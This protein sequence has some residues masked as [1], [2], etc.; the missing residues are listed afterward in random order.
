MASDSLRVEPSRE[1]IS[2]AILG[3]LKSWPALP[4]QVFIDVH[5]QGRSVEEVA[6]SRQMSSNEVTRILL[7]CERRLHQALHALLGEASSGVMA[8]TGRHVESLRSGCVF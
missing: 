2:R 8:H 4:R 7:H 3:C 5:Y 1:S 6:R